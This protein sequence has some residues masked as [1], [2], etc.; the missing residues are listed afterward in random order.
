MI[1]KLTPVTVTNLCPA[2]KDDGSICSTIV[3]IPFS[4]LELGISRDSYVFKDNIILPP[5][6]SCKGQETLFRYWFPVSLDNPGLKN[7]QVNNFLGKKLKEAG[8]INNGCRDEIMKETSDPPTI[9][10]DYPS[11]AGYV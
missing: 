10:A 6:T 1:I 3:E 2:I 8:Q 5:C 7:K 9:L 4:S 11:G